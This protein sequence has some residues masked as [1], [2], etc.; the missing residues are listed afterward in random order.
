LF[1]GSDGLDV[2]FPS[3]AK[4]VNLCGFGFARSLVTTPQAQVAATLLGLVVS[5][6]AAQQVRGR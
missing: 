1:L 6:L 2:L 4:A 3:G 5:F